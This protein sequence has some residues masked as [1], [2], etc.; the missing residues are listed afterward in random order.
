MSSI[1]L[2]QDGAPKARF[3]LFERTSVGRSSSCEIQ[4]LN[5]GLSRIHAVILKRE[6]GYWIEDAGSH[7]GTFVGGVRIGR[8]TR[9]SDGVD[10]Q[11]GT[12]SFIF[13]APV[14]IL[15][16]RG[17]DKT[18]CVLDA[19]TAGEV[20]VEELAGGLPLPSAQELSRIYSITCDIASELSLEKLLPRLL[21]KLM[22]YFGADRGVIL[23]REA[24]GMLIP[25]A[26]VSDKPSI[27]VSRTLIERAF[28]AKGPL[29]FSDAVDNLSFEG[30]KSILAHRLCAVMLVPLFSK[31]GRPMGIIQLDS[32]AAGAFTQETLGRLALLSKPAALSMEN[33]LLFEREVQKNSVALQRGAEA[34]ILTNDPA[35]AALLETATR[36]AE[37]SARVLISGESGTGKELIAR[38]IHQAGPRSDKPFVAVNCGAILETVLES[39]LFG[40]EKGAFTGA[41]K[42]RRG[43]FELADSGT[44]FLDEVG[45]LSPATQVKLLRVLQEG[46]FYP[47][48][49]ERPLRVDVRVL[50]ATNRDLKKM[51]EDGGFREDLYFRIKVI[52]LHVPPLRDRPKDVAMLAFAF[53]ERF[54]RTMGKSPPALSDGALRLL[55]QYAWPGNVRELQNNM[56]RLVVLTSGGEIVPADLPP[57]ISS[58][59][60]SIDLPPSGSLKDALAEMERRMI[61][62]ALEDT[63]GRKAEACRRLGISR[64]TLDKKMDE[65]GIKP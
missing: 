7:N 25:R 49:S 16:E 34:G 9:L 8:S 48:G 44:L 61:L 14:D 65:F 3:A 38:L 27:A 11:L 23:T 42:K 19:Q 64:P 54:S 39:E 57:E 50:A 30:A 22:T 17:G 10:V 15:H 28:S 45:E 59:P 62:R 1:L 6:D 58:H 20:A 2:L 47:V 55:T 5:P 35:M 18:V 26:V 37:S 13:N 43:C 60:P 24:S 53:L 51:V 12:V 36:A 4:I 29:L 31:A 52:Q 46:V 40:H 41:V 32:R 33:A 56:E 21:E 63:H